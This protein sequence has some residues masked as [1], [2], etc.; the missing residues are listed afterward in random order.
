MALL[1]GALRGAGLQSGDRVAFLSLN[2]HRLLEA[3]YG[4]LEAGGVLL[5]LNIRLAAPELIY[6]LNDSGATILFLEQEFAGFVDSF[7]RELRS[8]RSFYQLDGTP[9][10][11]WLSAYTYEQMLVSAMPHRGELMAFDENSVAEIFYTSGTGAR[12]KGVMLT[13]R[14]VY[15]HAMNMV[16]QQHTCFA[17]VRHSVVSRKWLGGGSYDYPGGWNACHASAV[18]AG[19][20]IPFGRA[21]ACDRVEFGAHHGDGAGRLACA[22]SI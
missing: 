1:A 18:R 17:D 20:S 15:L 19:G 2:C 21:G 4:V 14:N 8:V 12:P 11:E 3:Y 5:P 13:H 6:I 9:Q 7:R 22:C 16:V 10:T